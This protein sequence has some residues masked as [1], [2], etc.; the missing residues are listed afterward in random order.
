M[1]ARAQN[2]NPSIL[3]W[4]RETAG[5]HIDETAKKLGLSSSQKSSATEKIEVFEEGEKKPTR[6]QLLELA[7]MYHRSLAVFCLNEPPRESDRGEDF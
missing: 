3:T 1:A 4:A 2:I 7:K 6:K 5:R